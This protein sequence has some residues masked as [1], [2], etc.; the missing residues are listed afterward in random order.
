MA[1]RYAPG[2]TVSHRQ[3]QVPPECMEEDVQW[4]PRGLVQ[5]TRLYEVLFIEAIDHHHT[6]SCLSIQMAVL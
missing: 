1:R 2:I 4:F 5:D 6:I 3:P